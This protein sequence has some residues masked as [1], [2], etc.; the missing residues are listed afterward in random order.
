LKV[1][2]GGIRVALVCVAVA[3]LSLAGCGRKSM[4]DP[5]PSASSAAAPQAPA[6]QDAPALGEPDHGQVD[7]ERQ[8]DSERQAAGTPAKKTFFLDKLLN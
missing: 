8:S 6:T 7:N 1:S 4:L 3:T 2:S 5:P